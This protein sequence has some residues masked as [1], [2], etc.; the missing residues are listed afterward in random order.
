MAR[1]GTYEVLACQADGANHSWQ[2]SR[3][4]GFADAYIRCPVQPDGANE[5]MVARNTGGPGG[6]PG[7]SLAKVTFN[8]PPGARIVNARGWI[9]QNSTGGWQAGIHEASPSAWV[10][11]G[12]GCT[13]TFGT[14]VAF[15]VPL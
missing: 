6:A 10:W 1:A 15:N 7:L 11:C 12:V 3:S 9:K 14:W 2:A 4:N 8:A 5:G 13:S